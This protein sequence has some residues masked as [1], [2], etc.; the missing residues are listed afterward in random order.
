MP[1][2]RDP[3][4]SQTPSLE[5]LNSASAAAATPAV[6]DAT[7]AA[8]ISSSPEAAAVDDNAKA[9]EPVAPVVE[10][11]AVPE[12]PV[13]LLDKHD[14]DQAAKDAAAAKPAEDKKPEDEAKP[15]EGE[16]K[17][18]PAPAEGDKPAEVVADAPAELPKIDYFDGEKAIK[19]PEV[20]K[21]DDAAKASFTEALDSF[22]KDPSMGAQ[23]IIDMGA[24][25]FQDYATELHAKQWQTFNEM[26]GGWV[27]DVM[28]DP[29][30]GG[31]GHDTAMGTVAR[32]RDRIISNAPVGSER[33]KTEQAE[34]QQFLDTTGAGDNRAL[35]RALHNAGR[36]ID[37]AKPV[38]P[39][40]RPAKDNGRGPS[41]GKLSYNHPT[42][43]T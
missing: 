14:A 15:V 30:L 13:S 36:F 42:S 3:D 39:D 23:A 8:P 26:R 43:Q 32:V 34:W 33:Y 5:I 17:A 22:R 7:A 28:S 21:M 10:T 29:V 19:L 4:G 1:D 12:K 16:K 38:T 20:L 6:V 25:A 18:E 40:I 31:A 27:K 35:L 37:E 11:S 2:T 9:V 24:K 41:R